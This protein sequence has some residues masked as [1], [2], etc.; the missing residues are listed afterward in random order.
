MHKIGWETTML[1]YRDLK[2]A[3]RQGKAPPSGSGDG[4]AGALLLL[5][6]VGLCIL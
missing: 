6:I 2:E 5:W 3:E 4:S 1:D